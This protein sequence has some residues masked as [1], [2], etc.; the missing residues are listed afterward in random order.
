MPRSLERSTRPVFWP[1]AVILKIKC[2]LS[3][4][5][6]VSLLLLAFLLAVSLTSYSR[7]DQSFNTASKSMTE[8]LIGPIGAHAADLLIQTLGLAAALIPLLL[9]SWGWKLI[10]KQGV[11]VI[12][13]RLMMLFAALL[14]ISIFL[15][16]FNQPEYWPLNPGLGG[17]TGMIVY[18]FLFSFLSQFQLGFEAIIISSISLTF[19]TVFFCFCHRLKK[20]RVVGPL[21][22]FRNNFG[23]C[24][25]KNHQY[26]GIR[27]LQ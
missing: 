24:W 25:Q 7:Y 17:V 18:T 22:S 15:S 20:I 5:V 16:S 6:G 3:E 1:P 12:W 21:H 9:I 19:G 11:S 8:N 14:L 23:F 26:K 13:A 2:W 10:T 27:L 4:G